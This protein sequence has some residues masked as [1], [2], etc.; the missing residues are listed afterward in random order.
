M[1]PLC[2]AKKTSKFALCLSEGVSLDR[3]ASKWTQLFQEY[4]VTA[5]RYAW[6]SKAVCD[7]VGGTVKTDACAA[8]GPFGD[9]SSTYFQECDSDA[10]CAAAVSSHCCFDNVLM[11]EAWAAKLLLSFP[12]L[13]QLSN[14]RLSLTAMRWR[15]HQPTSFGESCPYPHPCLCTLS[16][17]C[18]RRDHGMGKVAESWHCKG[19]SPSCKRRIRSSTS[20]P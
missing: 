19:S 20:A 8:A 5:A 18:K 13:A 11:V 16:R 3:V 9:M 12:A 17:S 6:W 15:E 14:K 1:G 2:S 7:F 10:D 4:F